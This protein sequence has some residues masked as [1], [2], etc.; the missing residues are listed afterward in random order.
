MHD[1]L[2]FQIEESHDDAKPSEEYLKGL[3]D[4]KRAIDDFNKS[5][6]IDPNYYKS[7]NNRG[8]AK[9]YLGNINSAIDDFDQA[10]EINPNYGIAYYN[11]GVAK[12]ELGDNR[13]ACFDY[14]QAIGFA[15][16]DLRQWIQ[17]Q[18]NGWCFERVKN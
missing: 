1:R 13:G 10:I 6:E 9:K 5:I 18:I 4:T 7:Y 3:A 17:K 16:E 11:R 14:D 8:N 2:L 12:Q 15:N